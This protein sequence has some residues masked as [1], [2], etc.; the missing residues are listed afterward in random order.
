MGIAQENNAAMAKTRR[1][2]ISSHSRYLIL[3]AWLGFVEVPGSHSQTQDAAGG[4]A[5]PNNSNAGDIT[6]EQLRRYYAAELSG[7]EDNQSQDQLES[8][9]KKVGE[10]VKTFFDNFSNT[11]SKEQVR[12]QRMGNNDREED[13]AKQD[14]NY[15]ILPHTVGTTTAFEEIRTDGKGRS[16]NPTVMRGFILTKGYAGMNIVLHPDHQFGSHFYYLGKQTSDPYAYVIAFAQR[17]E[18]RDYLSYYS[19]SGSKD[20]TPVLLKGIAWVNPQS[21]QISR[22]RTDLLTSYVQAG[23]ME[24]ITDIR[25]SE[26]G[27]TA[28]QLPMSLPQE[29]TVSCVIGGI[30]YRNRHRY[31]DYKVFSVESYDKINEPVIKK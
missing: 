20:A 10:R 31:L 3:A 5:D 23:L 24:Q 6:L 19:G 30:S 27:S 16:I 4:V 17:P 12:M 1:Q 26:V 13:S 15:L 22:L 7:L 14:F 21:F 25:F 28:S 9:L 18:A 29:V 8:L 11:A 2:F